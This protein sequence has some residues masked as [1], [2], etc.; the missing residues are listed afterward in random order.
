MGM[1]HTDTER[2]P[3]GLIRHT[4]SWLS[5]ANGDA[6]LLCDGIEGPQ[7]TGV[8]SHVSTAPNGA[9]PP[10]DNYDVTLLDQWDYDALDGAGDN[11]DTANAELAVVAHEL[12]AQ[13]IDIATLGLLTL[14]V[15]NAGDTKA[16]LIEL[17]L[18]D[19]S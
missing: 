8:L 6:S 4:F 1:V 3:L 7:L 19:A 14:T 15:A 11:R 16:G 5:D 17:Y 13:T 9:V 18:V 2:S 10:T 12:T